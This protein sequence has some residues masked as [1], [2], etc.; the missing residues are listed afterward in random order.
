MKKTKVPHLCGGTFFALVLQARKAGGS[1][2]EKLN[3]SSKNLTAANVFAGLTKVLIGESILTKGDTLK[4]CASLYKTCQTCSGINV[5]FTDT[6]TVSSFDSSIKAKNPAIYE[7]MTEFINI[8]LNQDKCEWLVRALVETIQHDACIPETTLFSIDYDQT[9]AKSGLDKIKGVV[10]QAFL[11]SVLHYVVMN[12]PDSES[13]RPTFEIWFSHGGKGAEWK[14]CGNAGD[15]IHPMRVLLSNYDSDVENKISANNNQEDADAD[16][17]AGVPLVVNQVAPD[18][19]NLLSAKIY[20]ID[21]DLF[22]DDD[23]ETEEKSHSLPFFKYLKGASDFYSCKKT[24]LNP[25]EPLPFYDLYIC[26]DLKYHRQQ[27]NV[28]INEIKS[29]ILISNG[30]IQRL[31]EESK[32][33][34]IEG[35]GGIGKSMYLTHLFLSSASEY[36]NTGIVPIFLMLKDYKESTL[37][38]LDFLLTEVNT[39]DNAVT[40]N[41]IVSALEDNKLVLLLDGL[42]EIQTLVKNNFVADL[43][44]FIKSYPGNTVI[45][46][47]RPV[48]SFVSYARFSLFDIQPLAKKQ[49]INLIRK[50]KFWDEEGKQAFI[51]ALDR[52]LYSS[53]YQFAGN[54]LLLTIMLMTFSTFGEVPAK[55]HVFYAKAYETMARLHDATKG[56]FKRPLHTG[57]TPEDF[58]KYYS[59]FCARTYI[60]EILEFNEQTF[61]QYMGNV[62]KGDSAKALGATPR[63][64]LKDLT[65]YLCIMYKEGPKYYFIHRSFQEYFAAFYFAYG[66]DNR[67]TQLGEFFDEAWHRSYTDRTFDMLYDMVPEKVEQL[68]FYPILSKFFKKWNEEGES[69]AYWKFL[70]DQYPSIFIENGE[71]SDIVSNSPRSYIYG[72]LVQLHNLGMYSFLNFRVMAWPHQIYEMK[73]TNYYEIYQAFLYPETYNRY[74]EALKIPDDVLNETTVAS[75][76][77]IPHRYYEYF[78]EPDQVGEIVELEINEL[79]Y[80]PLR[81]KELVLFM[82]DEEFPLKIE[83]LKVKQYFDKLEAHIK[84]EQKSDRLF[85]D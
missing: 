58:A 33:I 24:L 77:E 48:Y 9:I 72:K 12:A 74:P 42:D 5:P 65:D 16:G 55:M 23:N 19:S 79:Q 61:S 63:Q 34:I 78:G 27:R 62:I 3:G 70:R 76:D 44:A 31:E 17:M 45:I 1:A 71:T 64:F 21:D 67:L 69:E 18:L 51:K 50:L 11:V 37:N 53:H 13:G 43:E 22:E 6:A 26:N 15:T 7:R 20:M 73:K 14:Y 35:T 85:G 38:I 56:S 29:E 60:K 32:Y 68:I 39:F 52:H 54:P 41:D 40:Q 36:E 59:E 80:N 4:K 10:L 28:G 2:R 49:A 57:L 84:R 30:T 83:F 8:Y 75:G 82:E 66:F 81:Y 46:T 25:E 47:S